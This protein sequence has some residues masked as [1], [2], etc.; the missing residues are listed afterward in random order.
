MTY[1]VSAKLVVWTARSRGN[2]LKLAVSTN[3]WECLLGLLAVAGAELAA[4]AS[5]F[6]SNEHGPARAE[7]VSGI[8]CA[9]ST[10]SGT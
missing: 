7:N 10:M 8:G 3:N 9:E 5:G 2:S 4:R 1:C 6:L